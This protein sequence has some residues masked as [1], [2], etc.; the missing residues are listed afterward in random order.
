MDDRKLAAL[1]VRTSSGWITSRGFALDV[2]TDLSFSGTIVPCGIRDHGVV[3][4]R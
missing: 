4:V 1:G 2:T 3:S